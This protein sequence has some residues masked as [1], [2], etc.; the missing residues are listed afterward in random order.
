MRRQKEVASLVKPKLQL[1]QQ[2]TEKDTRMSNL[3]TLKLTDAKKPTQIPQVLQRRNKLIKRI[4]QQ[5]ELARAQQTGSSFS[6]KKFRSVADSQTGARKQVET[7]MRV[8]PWWFVTEN[9]KLAISVRYGSKVLELGKG[10]FAVEVGTEKDLVKVLDVIK[11]AVSAGEL[12]TAIENA[13]TK[14]RDGFT[15]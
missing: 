13:A 12:D 5:T 1:L 9:G 6:V 4:W 2:T 3:N 10:K 15:K 7:D 14:L 8:K 11:T